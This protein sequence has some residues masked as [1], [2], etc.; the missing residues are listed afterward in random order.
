MCLKLPDP[1]HPLVILGSQR[2]ASPELNDNEQPHDFRRIYQRQRRQS[3]LNPQIRQQSEC[4]DQQGGPA[5]DGKE[6]DR[7][8][9]R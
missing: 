8:A 3:W 7:H 2:R 4:C 5:Y 6:P 1:S 9:D